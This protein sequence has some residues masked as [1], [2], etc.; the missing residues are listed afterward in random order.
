MRESRSERYSYRLGKALGTAVL[1]IMAGLVLA[2]PV[3]TGAPAQA[4]VASAQPLVGIV[5]TPSGHG[6][7]QVAADGGVFAFGD[8]GFYGS[9]GG[10]HLNSPVVGMAA[11]PDSGGYWLVAADGGVFAFGDAHFYGSM[12]GKPLNKPVVGMAATPDGGGYWLVAAD[13]GV[14]A[15]GNAGFHGSMGGKPLNADVVG[16]AATPDGGG[17]WLVAADGGVF[18][19]GD[20]GFY[21]SMGGKPLNAQVVGMTA[22]LK[23]T[24]YWL[25]AADGGVFAFGNA[26]FYGS[27]GGKPLAG[28]VDSIARVPAGGGY[29]L[30]ATDGGVF[31]FGSA[32]YYGRAVY[33]PPQP[34]TGTYAFI[35]PRGSVNPS[36]LELPHH[37]YPAIDIPVP[38]GTRYYAVTGGTVVTFTDS[39]CG[40]GLTLRGDDSAS[41]TYCHASSLLVKSGRV[42]A[43]TLLGYTGATGDATGAHL[44]FQIQIPAGTLRC[45]QTFLQAIFNGRP[46]P[47]VGSLP[48]SG[49]IQ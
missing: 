48:T 10:Q 44:H 1:A 7:W 3:L 27:M 18:A 5:S 39:R 20:A 29:W 30:S 21:G 34:P 31:A 43:G 32:A 24:G 42:S 33:I 45:P 28:A 4:A 12:G 23:G 38:S 15:F 41:Y 19:F 37:D 6:Y 16:M 17:Y 22:T 11:T 8:A 47:A 25:V 35:L 14:F 36:W 49:C 46:V 26:G 2:G 40:N 9:M 13:G